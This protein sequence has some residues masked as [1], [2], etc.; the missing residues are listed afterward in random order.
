MGETLAET[1]IEIDAKK[2]ELERTSAQ[3]RDVAR[4]PEARQGE[5]APDHRH[6]RNGR[7]PDRRRARRSWR[8]SC[9]AASSRRDA[10]KA[11]DS[12]P[13]ADAVLD[14]SHGGSCRTSGRRGSRVP[15]EELAAWRSNPRKNGKISK[16]LAKQIAEGPPGPSRTAWTVAEAVA[17]VVLTAIARK[18]VMRV[19]SG[20]PEDQTPAS[21][22]PSDSGKGSKAVAAPPRAATKPAKSGPKPAAKNDA[23]RYVADGYSAMSAPPKG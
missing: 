18:A 23:S 11:F 13:K 4:R 22:A 14:R 9:G 1:R 15:R 5:P 6:R 12:P 2:A 8:P 17:T 16:K 21:P 10:E 19:I 3:L 7:V 20:Q